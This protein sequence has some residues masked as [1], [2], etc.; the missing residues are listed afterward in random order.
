MPSSS[1]LRAP[2]GLVAWALLA[3]VLALVVTSTGVLLLSNRAGQSADRASE[4]ADSYRQLEVSLLHAEVARHD[5]LL[6]GGSPTD[7]M[8]VLGH[9]EQ[10]WHVIERLQSAEHGA[11]VAEL[12]EVLDRYRSAV[13]AVV[14]GI[15]LDRP[16]PGAE[17]RADTAAARVVR[18]ARE[19]TELHDEE[20]A[21]ELARMR[22][23]Q[24]GAARVFPLVAVLSL[25]LVGACIRLLTVQRRR[26]A[27]LREDA[28]RRAVTD[29]LTG[30]ANRA[31]LRAALEE[32]LGN[33]PSRRPL[34]VLLL[35]LNDFKAV[36]DTYGHELG[37]AVLQAVAGRLLDAAPGGA[38]VARLGGDEFVVLVPD[39]DRAAAHE[40]ADAFHTALSVPAV[41]HSVR[42][43]V[44]ASIGVALDDGSAGSSE[45]KA[46]DLLRRADIAMYSSKTSKSG[47]V[48][49]SD[50]LDQ[51]V[52]RVPQRET[53]SAQRPRAAAG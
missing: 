51:L 38:L 18:H 50:S 10:R 14:N 4:V 31:G 23:L 36:N 20:A 47:P 35:D 3:T 49:W 46:S 48:L 5:L 43:D 42:T 2:S 8:Y 40:A 21:A 16:A 45:A 44:G 15:R 52:A 27:G 26:L 37:D 39:A 13:D 24:H 9:V 32:V 33:G 19:Q 17:A 7:L 22:S 53:A 28:H 41:V 11:H 30:L 6:E 34:A 25:G 1:H 12:G 29:E